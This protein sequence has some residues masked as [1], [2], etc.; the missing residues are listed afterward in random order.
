MEKL[1][2]E[3][4]AKAYDELLVKAKELKESN[5]KDILAW[6]EEQTEQDWN[7]SPQKQFPTKVIIGADR[8]TGTLND[9][10]V[11]QDLTDNIKKEY[12][13]LDKVYDLLKHLKD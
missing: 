13:R 9:Y 7:D 8:E 1:S 11:L 12:I 4:K 5:P 6:L 10:W 3:E 2:I